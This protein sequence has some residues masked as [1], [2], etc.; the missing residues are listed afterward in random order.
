VIIID[1]PHRHQPASAPAL[2]LD[3]DGVI[4]RDDGYV[5]R[6]EDFHFLDGI[7]DL[8]RVAVG[9]GYVIVVATNQAGIARGSYTE[10]DFRRLSL[11]MLDQMA[12][13]GVDVA[14]VAAC[15][16]HPDFPSTGTTGPCGCRKPAPGM[17]LRAAADLSLDLPGSILIGSRESDM[18][19][20]LAA[21]VGTRLLFA[22]PAERPTLSATSATAILSS[23]DRAVEYFREGR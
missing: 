2:F 18:E 10:D 15:P 21:G 12:A 6:I 5:H 19:A 14:R 17:L 8:G 20:G 23:L 3:R 1:S 13:E 11:W 16:H 22:P 7:L 4:N 9:N